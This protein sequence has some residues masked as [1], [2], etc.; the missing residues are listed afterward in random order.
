MTE[1]LKEKLKRFFKDRINILLV[2]LISFAIIYR[3]FY[4]FKL[5]PQPIWWDEADYLSIAKI[6]ATGMQHPDWFSH[7]TGM[8][9]LLMPIVWFIFFKAGLGEISIRFFTL[10]LPGIAIICF[11]YALG[12]ELYGKT[13]GL[14]AGLIMSVYWVS[15][16]YTFRILTDIPAVFLG[17]LSFYFFYAHYI[18]KNKSSGLYL[19]VLFGVLGF[20]ARFP[21]ALVPVTWAVYLLITR[22]F[23][24]FRDK[25]FWKSV[26]LL[27]ILLSPYII[28]FILTKFYLFNFYFGESAV[29][30]K[31]PIALYV[32]SM[33]P[34]FMHNVFAISLLIG[35][36]AFVPLILGFDI[37]LKQKDKS[38]N[39]DFFVLLWLAVHL[40]FYVVIFKA[41]NDRWLLMLM[42]AVFY[43]SAKGIKLVYDFIKKY[44]K[45]LAIITLVLILLIGSYQ[46]LN[47]TSQLIEQK[48][49]TYKE[50]KDAGL[51]LKANTPADT[52]IITASIVQNQYYSERQSDG[53][54]TNDSIWE[55]C[56]DTYGNLNTNDS[57][58]KA[59]EDAFN[60]RITEIKP[61]YLIVSVFEPVFTPQW[62]YSY[63]QR[64]NLTFINAYADS[65]N[66]L[67]LAIY[68][69]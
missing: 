60:T 27:L 67:M 34:E 39:A 62:A 22:R 69:F 12:R 4:F 7:F 15:S 66:Q 55:S 59:T 30:M 8:R 25:A 21:I 10:L 13:I 9:P 33:I 28:Y 44:N 45:V 26:I 64:Y 29:S 49:D 53:F 3:L 65:Q 2:L 1:D 19:A 14:I 52:K 54:Y 48:K 31:Q 32:F 24:I 42:P 16:F 47:H 63:P 36:F 50:I 6:W 11:V 58:Q 46:N 61:D 68:K 20:S 17:M 37:F 5:G 57:C 51:W 56:T 38:L 18:K 35:L 41:A 23:S 43:I 40:V